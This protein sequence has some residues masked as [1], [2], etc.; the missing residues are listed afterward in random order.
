MTFL[1]AGLTDVYSVS[2]SARLALLLNLCSRSEKLAP[3]PLFYWGGSMPLR[4]GHCAQGESRCC[5]RV[6]NTTQ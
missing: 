5:G 4:G 6:S 1:D 3:A 2:L